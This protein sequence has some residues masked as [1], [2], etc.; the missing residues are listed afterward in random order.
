M[1]LFGGIYLGVNYYATPYWGEPIYFFM[2]WE[3]STS[4]IIGIAMFFIGAGAQLA[5]SFLIAK[6]KLKPLHY[7]DFSKT[8]TDSVSRGGDTRTKTD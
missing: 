1:F 4:L 3:D 2:T 8:P 5:S 6:T 7:K